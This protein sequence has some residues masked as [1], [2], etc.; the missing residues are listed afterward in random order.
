MLL[1]LRKFKGFSE[2]YALKL[3]WGQRPIF[4][5]TNCNITGNKYK[6][7]KAMMGEQ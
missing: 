5:T 3:L 4:L 1:S 6:S 7:P 2:L